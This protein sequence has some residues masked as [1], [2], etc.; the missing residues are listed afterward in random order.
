MRNYGIVAGKL[1]ELTEVS[2]IA[3][4]NLIQC[5][6]LEIGESPRYPN[7]GIPA[8]ETI[9]TQIYPD[10]YMQQIQ[11][12]YAANFASLMITKQPVFDPTYT[13]NII[14]K[15]GQTINGTIAV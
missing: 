12:Q 9:L 11:S 8:R 15:D 2:A 4:C 3:V 13:I 10:Y 6:K 7:R 14:T 5:C 1:V